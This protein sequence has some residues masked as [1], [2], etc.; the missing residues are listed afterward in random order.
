MTAEN[1]TTALSSTG[2]FISPSV[3]LRWPVEETGRNSVTPS[4]TPRTTA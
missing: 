2:M 1:P 3:I 4:T